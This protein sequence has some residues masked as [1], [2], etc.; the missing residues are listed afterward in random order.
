MPQTWFFTLVKN[1]GHTAR[2]SKHVQGKATKTRFLKIGSQIWV[3]EPSET[4]VQTLLFEEK[5]LLQSLPEI[6]LRILRP[7]SRYLEGVPNLVLYAGKKIRIIPHTK[8]IICKEKR[9]KPDFWKSGL[10]IWLGGPEKISV[11]T[12]FFETKLLLQ[13]LPENFLRILRPCSRYLE[14]VPHLVLYTGKKI[15]AIPHTKHFIWKETRKKVDFL[16]NRV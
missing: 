7:C 14:G 6:V 4:S 15:R 3:V 8:Q 10:K 11:K 16:K 12:V 5:L 2:Q 1:Q 9:Q 13:N